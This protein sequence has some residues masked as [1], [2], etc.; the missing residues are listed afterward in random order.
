MIE[1]K[2]FRRIDDG[3]YVQIS[4]RVKGRV[5]QGL[6]VADNRDPAFELLYYAAR[7]P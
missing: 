6:F 3:L 1:E 5:L 2:T 4:Q 7:V